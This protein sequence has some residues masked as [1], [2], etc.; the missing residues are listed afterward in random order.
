MA[1]E[2]TLPR[3]KVFADIFLCITAAA[4]A[5]F[6]MREIFHLLLASWLFVQAAMIGMVGLVSIWFLNLVRGAPPVAISESC[7]IADEPRNSSFD[8]S[9]WANFVD[10]EETA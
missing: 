4:V 6:G 9:I 1:R 8:I 2:T 3:S 5:A 10:P 7:E